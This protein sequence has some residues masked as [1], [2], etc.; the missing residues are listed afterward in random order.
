MHKDILAHLAAVT[1]EEQ[2]FLDGG[3]TI[4][5]DIYMQGA[6]NTVN[7]G[8]L[9]AA[10]KLITIRPHTRF[11]PFPE[12]THDYVEI[13]YMC[14][15]S[16][17]HTVNGKNIRLEQGDL[18]FLNQGAVHAVGKAGQGDIAV[19]FIVLPEFFSVPLTMIGEEPTPLR[20]FLVGCLC[21]DVAGA[22]YLHFRVSHV[23]PVQN[24]IENLLWS[25]IR[26][27]PGK[28]RI[29]QVTMALLLMQ[30]LAHTDTLTTHDREDA[31]VWQVLRYVEENFARG[32]FAQ[33]AAQL[34]YDGPW[35][36]RKIKQKTG[37]T[38]TQLLQEKRL[39]QAAFLL[40][41]TRRTI[42]DIC[43]AVGYENLSFFHRIFVERFGLSPKHY[44]DQA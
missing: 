13:V 5:R 39:T 40:R 41:S 4:D 35:L 26:E 19:N 25:L 17:T 28:R 29:S 21:G 30:L 2:V 24:L 12:H 11:V 32:S 15:G 14:A 43:T 20:Q 38:F 10:G 44:R 27:T 1:P 37:R 9:L 31:L 33:L 6:E 34:H 42:A 3:T 18:L 22:G 8:K 16:T 36:S 7:A 23:A